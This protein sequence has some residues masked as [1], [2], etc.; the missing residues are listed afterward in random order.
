MSAVINVNFFNKIGRFSILYVLAAPIYI[1][2]TGEYNDPPKLAIAILS[3]FVIVTTLSYWKKPKKNLR[4]RLLDRL[5]VI[6]IMAIAFAYGNDNSRAFISAGAYLYLI[7][8]SG[9]FKDY[10][11]YINHIVF[12][13]FAG[14]GVLMY[15]VQD[16]TWNQIFVLFNFLTILGLLFLNLKNLKNT[17]NFDKSEEIRESILI[18]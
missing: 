18:F 4:W 17:K 5:T 11:S 2:A 1:F 8:Y 12:R 16:F 9:G 13:F 3:L 15:I 14:L 7:G 6:S 10:N